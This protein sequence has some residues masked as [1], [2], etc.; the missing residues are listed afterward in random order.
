MTNPPF[1]SKGK[2]TDKRIL[3]Q[4][5]LAYKWTKT[6]DKTFEKTTK[7]QNGQVPDILFIERCLEFL[8]PYG[9]MAIVLPDGDLT[10]STLEYVRYFIDQ[11]AR[12]V[13]VVSLPSETFVHSGA[14]VKGSVLFLQKLPKEELEKL[15]HR[16]YKIFTAVIEKIG[17][18]IRGRTVFKKDDEGNII[19]KE[20][21]IL[22]HDGAKQKQL[23]PIIDTDIPD[24]IEQFRKF[25]KEEK[26]NW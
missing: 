16:N 21:K 24:I 17:Y 4:F 26:L 12:F 10:N 25:I 18:D 22:N 1:G 9:R 23:L 20:I 11:K 15:K 13:A 3:E 5:D 7:L 19:K 6:K 2:V 14:S 8:K